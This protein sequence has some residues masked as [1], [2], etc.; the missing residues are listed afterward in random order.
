MDPQ[1]VLTRLN[2]GR[3]DGETDNRFENCF[4]GTE[5]L[6][7]VL[8]PQHSLI[9]GNK[10]S[11]KSAI[12]RLL[13]DDLQ[14]VKPLLPKTFDNIYCVPAYGLQSEEFLPDLDVL[15]LKPDTVDDF[16]YHWLLYLGLKM[17]WWL[18]K[19]EELKAAIDRGKDENV[20]TAFATLHRILIDVGLVDDATLF[21]KLKYH[22][23]SKPKRTP[24]KQNKERA[25]SGEEKPYNAEFRKKTGISIIALLENVDTVLQGTNR[26]MWLMLDKLDLLYVDDIMK[27]RAS[28]TG[29][30]QLLVQYGNQFRNIHFKI[31]LRNDIYRQLH[32]VN[33]SHLISYTTEMKWRGPLLLK[34][35]VARA[36]VDTHVREY[37]SEMSGEKVDVTDVILGSEE[38]VKKIFY[39]IFEPTVGSNRPQDNAPPTDQW[40]LRRLIDGTESSFPR[41]LI[42]LG[43]KAVEKQREINRSSGRHHSAHL[44]GPKAL[45]EAFGEISTYRCD[46]YL[47]SEF[48]HLA[49]HF[50]VFRGSDSSTFH[51]EELYMLFEPLSP[52][53]D[54]AIRA[55]Y[56]TGLLHPLGKNVDSSRKFKVPL[57]YRSGLGMSDRGKPHHHHHQREQSSGDQ[58]AGEHALQHY[59]KM[60]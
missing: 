20:K 2:F 35:L 32:I 47:Y 58:S 49:R 28:I 14:K 29:L 57:L 39:T 34:L 24:K 43:N 36:V 21:T 59:P 31:F 38:Y 19:D 10:G 16:R 41:E 50:D 7:Q 33:K 53:G 60:N 6:R 18:V 55:V 42:H 17:S 3:V 46:T 23:A 13:C 56:D 52:K 9:V 37:C 51:R 8:L 5:M 4:I 54:E 40:I 30:V 12:C 44:I 11:G 15:E 27:L 22:F 45:K 1:Q 48:P 25:S 26:L